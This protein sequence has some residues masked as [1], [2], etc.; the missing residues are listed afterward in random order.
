MSASTSSA[1]VDRERGYSPVEGV[2]ELH[3]DA[4]DAVTDLY[5]REELQR[6]R[7]RTEAAIRRAEETCCD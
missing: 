3:A 6:R 4:A 1:G 2:Y 7:E 5:A